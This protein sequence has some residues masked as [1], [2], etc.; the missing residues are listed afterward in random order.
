MISSNVVAVI[1]SYSSTATEPAA[2]IY[3]EAGI[4]HIT[5][6]S[7]AARSLKR[8]LN[9]SSGRVSWM[10]GRDCLPLSLRVDTLGLSK[11]ALIHDNTTY[12]D[13]RIGRAFTWRKMAPQSFIMMRLLLVRKIFHRC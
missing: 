5:P 7:T 12:E 13:C 6:S 8:V 4:L 10:I 9:A 2:N 3:H 11:V 1:G